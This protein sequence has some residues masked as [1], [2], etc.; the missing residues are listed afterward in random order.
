MLDKTIMCCHKGM[1]K[2]DILIDDV[3]WP[4][5]EGIQLL[6]G[7]HF[8]PSWKDVLEDLL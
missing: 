1:I 5:F 3:L 6:Y 4:K 8:F 2:A 7:S